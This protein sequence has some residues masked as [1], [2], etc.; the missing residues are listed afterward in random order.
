MDKLTKKQRSL[1][2]AKIGGKDSS[3]E[4]KVRKRL[5]KEGFRYRVHYKKLSG[6]PDIVLVSRKITVFINGCFWHQHDCKK[7][8]LPT[9]NVS[10]W[11]N[12]LL[13]NKKR[14][15]E[16]LKKLRIAG[17]KSVILWECE[18]NNK[19]KFERSMNRLIKALRK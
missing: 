14:D 1:N 4:I 17:W 6:I 18:L 16:N 2:M 10:F 13:K 9:T 11:K 12:K 19:V 3:L 7:A 5:F 8:F 15:A